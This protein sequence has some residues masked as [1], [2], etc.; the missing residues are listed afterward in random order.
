MIRVTL[1]ERCRSKKATTIFEGLPDCFRW[2]NYKKIESIE[3][4]GMWKGTIYRP[5]L[6]KFLNMEVH[7]EGKVKYK[8][9]GHILL[10][11]ALIYN[12]KLNHVWVKSPTLKKAYWA[13]R[14]VVFKGRVCI[15]LHTRTKLKIGID[16]VKNIREA[17]EQ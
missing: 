15:Y 16:Q 10:K 11:P 13:G 12:T 3:P 14:H 1:H 17:Y 6:L 8:Y 2:L 5:Q 7:V 9:K 4:T